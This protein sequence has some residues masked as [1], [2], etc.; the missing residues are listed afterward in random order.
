M[1]A[2]T[3]SNPGKTVIK[4]IGLA[5]V[6]LKTEPSKFQT[7]K[8]YYQTFLSAKI[9]HENEVMAFLAYDEEHHRI[10]IVGLPG[11][12]PRD[13]NAA[14]LF[15]F[16]FTFNSLTDLALAY[17]QRLAH[18]I[19]PYWCVNHGPTTSIYYHDPDGN[20]IETQVDNFKT[21]EEANEFL[22]SP[23]FAVNPIGTDFDPEELIR[24][25]EAGED[26]KVITTRVE[27]GPRLF[28]IYNAEGK[29]IG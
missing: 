28:P 24:K 25:L 12:G 22:Q 3:F 29:V 20:D 16:A 1:A 13:P 8:K 15:H 7:M 4:P 11:T 10:A 23:A 26:E 19:E 21:V 14:G 2:P 9:Q 17:R 5:H 6:F 27:I 18:G